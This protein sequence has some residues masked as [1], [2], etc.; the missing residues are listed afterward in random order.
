M[1]RLLWCVVL[2]FM[3]T[4][5][6]SAAANRSSFQSSDGV[7]L[8]LLEAG[9]TSRGAKA[10]TIALIPGW[11][12]PATIW[13]RQIDAFGRRYHTLALDPR[14]QGESEIPRTGYTAERRATDIK[15]FLGSSSNVLLIGWSLGAIESLQY[16]HMF[17]SSQLAGLVLVDSSVGEG[18]ARKPSGNFQER[19]R[20]DRDSAVNE[21][22]RAIFAT[23]RSDSEIAELASDAKR[24]A[25]KDSLALLDY[26][27]ERSHWRSITRNFK[28]PLLYVATPQFEAQAG[29]LKKSRPRTQVEIFRK[30]GHA[31]FV[32]E[33]ERFNTLVESFA[34]KLLR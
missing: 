23:P 18:P 16:V 26:P 4:G 5:S 10:L 31:L 1:L 27:F 6:L 9:K 21:F 13:Q 11:T 19:L 32:D 17:G 2:L 15:E 12:M 29:Y 30:A 22:V 34:K 7:K 20:K 14:G 8:S 24:M 25:L 28:K 3:A 33:P